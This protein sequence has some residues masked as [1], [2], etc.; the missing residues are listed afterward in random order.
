V[1]ADDAR[2]TYDQLA[3][4]VDDVIRAQFS[5][6]RRFILIAASADVD[7]V[8]HLLAA[9]A[10]G[11]PV[12]IAPADDATKLKQWVQHFDPDIVVTRHRERLLVHERRTASAHELHPDLALLISTSGST[13]SSKL[14]RLSAANVQTNAEQIAASL[15]LT[16]HDRALITLPLPY[17]YGLSVVTSHLLS[18]AAL[19]LNDVSIVDSAFWD[20]AEQHSITTIAGVPYT[21]ELLDRIGP[22]RH[23]ERVPTL[24]QMTVS[25]GHVPAADV[26]RYVELAQALGFEFIAMYGQSEATARISI[27][28]MRDLISHP[29][30]VGLPLPGTTVELDV[31]AVRRLEHAHGAFDDGVGE[32]VFSGP[33]MMLGYAHSPSDFA[34][35]RTIEHLRTGDL[36]RADE[37][38][39]IEIVGREQRFSKIYGLRVDLQRIEDALHADGITAHIVNDDALLVVIVEHADAA[40]VVDQVRSI[41]GLPARAVTAITVD[42][43]PRTLAGKPD[44]QRLRELAHEH[45]LTLRHTTSADTA[46]RPS[47]PGDASGTGPAPIVIRA[48]PLAPVIPEAT[49][50][51]ATRLR[52]NASVESADP[53]AS[54][55]GPPVVDAEAIRADIAICLGR[56]DATV[57]DSFASLG[58][59]S[60][61]HV[62]MSVRLERMLGTL[63]PDW[64]T[65][66]AVELAASVRVADPEPTVPTASMSTLA[67]STA[68]AKQHVRRSWRRM[69]TTVIVR[70]LAITA[71]VAG[72]ARAFGLQGGATLLIAVAGYNVARFF[73]T[74]SARQVRVRNLIRATLSVAVP[75]L[76]WIWL[77]VLFSAQFTWVNGLLVHHLVG[78]PNWSNGWKYWFI[79]AL[80]ALLL[81]TTLLVAVPAFDRAERRW[82]FAVPFALAVIALLGRYHVLSTDPATTYV[83]T[84]TFAA[85]V[86]ALGWA[87]QR[88]RTL[89]ERIAVV[90]LVLLVVPGS[91]TQTDRVVILIAG[92]LLLLFAPT[93]RVPSFVVTPLATIASASLWIY[94]THWQ[95]Y[96]LLVKVN[97]WLALAASLAFGIAMSMAWTA[98]VKGLRAR[99]RRAHHEPPVDVLAHTSLVV[100]AAPTQSADPR[101]RFESTRDDDEGDVGAR[102]ANLGSLRL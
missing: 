70:A 26:A 2:L 87:V 57:D 75:S 67:R 37:C 58:G 82:P 33:N 95:I 54:P 20:T 23:L 18:G 89:V 28:R 52:Q 72:H 21:Y 69:D 41:A 98:G 88:A 30:T 47:R 74:D 17:A 80:V 38:G 93:I 42:E 85:W 31:D 5:G 12:F 78:T 63:P 27:A 36:A 34:D 66:S 59:D 1:I 61:S 4:R 86:F 84:P 53:T 91:Y 40:M 77:T 81:V 32:L 96:P 65:R 39:R 60:L 43:L 10:V 25:G 46:P 99:R 90:T 100:P 51:A 102:T 24:R 76:I 73:L 9:L 8:V 62:E 45:T 49:A 29:A 7:V 13:G 3:D 35:G 71:V 15:E 64:P 19:V 50:S 44:G 16:S 14:V 68:A 101:A 22:R 94:L 56:P 48:D 83:L 6:S 92:L 55:L 11:H 79:E 97:G